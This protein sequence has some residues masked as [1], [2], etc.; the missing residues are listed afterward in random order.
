LND[1]D[2]QDRPWEFAVVAIAN[3]RICGFLAASYQAWNRRLIIWHLYVDGSQRRRGIARLLVERTQIFAVAK[4]AVNMW[5]ETSS[6]NTPAITVYRRLGFELCGLDTTF[7][8]GTS[9]AGE[10]ALFFA[11]PI[12]EHRA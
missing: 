5:L 2:K 7:Y 1:L 9:A 3:D 4:S 11:R 8:Q 10:T 12:P 6:V